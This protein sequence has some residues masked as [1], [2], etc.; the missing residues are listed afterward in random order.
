[1]EFVP[2]LDLP[3][4]RQ[5]QVRHLRNQ[6][7]VRRFMYTSHEISEAEHARWLDQLKSNSR[8]AVFGVISDDQLIGAVSLSEINALQRTANWAFY[9]DARVQ[10]KGIGSQVEFWLLDYAFG[11]AQL[12]KLNCEVLEVNSAVIKMH[13]RFG[14]VLEG[15]RRQNAMYEGKRV[16]VVLLGITQEEWR[17]Q[18]PNLVPV[19]ERLAGK[20]NQ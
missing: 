17:Q 1:M 18:R 13:Q 6:P 14:F 20:G 10:G 2:I 3:A 12:E 16:D 4:T 8:H 19:I 9:L 15:V 5:A 7:E 11:P